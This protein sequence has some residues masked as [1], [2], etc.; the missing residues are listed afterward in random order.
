MAKKCEVCG[1]HPQSGRTVSHAHNVNHRIFYPNLRTLKTTVNGVPKKIKI[2][3]KCLKA[4]A[5]D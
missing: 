3:M 5:K 2:C 1:K 4:M